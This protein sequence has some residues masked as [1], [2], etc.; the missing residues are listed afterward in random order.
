MSQAVHPEEVEHPEPPRK[1]RWAAKVA[2]LCATVEFALLNLIV[3]IAWALCKI[4]AFPYSFLTLVLSVEAIL[5]TIFVLV[6]QRLES[7]AQRREIE[8]DL[9]NDAVA[10]EHSESTTHTLSE[11]VDRLTRIEDACSPTTGP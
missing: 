5:L 1:D 8:A 6:Q 9:K 2:D 4:E 3:V 10:A 7:E 11:I